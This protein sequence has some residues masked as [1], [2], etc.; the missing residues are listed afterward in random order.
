MEG[1]DPDLRAALRRAA[2]DAESAGV[3]LRVNSGWRSPEHQRRL[4]REA[5][6]RYGSADEAARWVATPE[7]SA[8]VSGEAV[9]IGPPDAAAWLC[10][11]GAAY[12]LCQIYRNEPWHFELRPDAVGNGCPPMYADPTEDPRMR[13]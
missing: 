7:T 11:H 3:R 4:L 2:A 5:V 13:R 6:A 8:H 10:E 9:D 12:G 1:L